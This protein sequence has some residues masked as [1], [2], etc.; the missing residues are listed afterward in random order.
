[1]PLPDNHIVLHPEPAV[2]YTGKFLLPL[3]Q[4]SIALQDSFSDVI[5]FSFAFTFPP[6]IIIKKPA[7]VKQDANLESVGDIHRTGFLLY[8]EAQP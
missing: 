1:M 6:N 5:L 8:T 3:L 4:L 7:Y 2:H